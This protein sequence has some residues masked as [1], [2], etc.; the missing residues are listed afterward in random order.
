MPVGSSGRVVIEM[1]PEL[2]QLL[3]QL[4]KSDGS[5]LKD[6]FLKC[7]DEYMKSKTQQKVLF[8]KRGRPIRRAVR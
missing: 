1:D 8:D 6:W 2:K 7:V 5:N 3:H 4:L